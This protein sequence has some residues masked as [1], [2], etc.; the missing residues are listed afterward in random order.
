ML[1][2]TGL[3][4]LLF[5]QGFTARIKGLHDDDPTQHESMLAFPNAGHASKNDGDEGGQVGQHDHDANPNQEK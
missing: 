4:E 1:A 2:L 5:F 3:R